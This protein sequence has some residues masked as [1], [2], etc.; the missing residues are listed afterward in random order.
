MQQQ[1]VLQTSKLHSPE[2]QNFLR[3]L[4]KILDCTCTI[5]LR[6]YTHSHIVKVINSFPHFIERALK[7]RLFS[8]SIFL[9]RCIEDVVIRS[10]KD[11]THRLLFHCKGD[12][13]SLNNH[14]DS[15]H[16]NQNCPR[17]IN[18]RF[19]KK[20]SLTRNWIATNCLLC[21]VF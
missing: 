15:A 16:S 6:A 21:N 18:R 4:G 2:T 7:A 3:R 19:P 20:F 5:A 12:I 9:W 17:C 10:F 11:N 14:S 1:I 13:H 8:M